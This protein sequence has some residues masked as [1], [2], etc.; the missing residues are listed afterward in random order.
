MVLPLIAV[1]VILAAVV[2]GLVVFLGRGNT[3][4]GQHR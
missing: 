1:A 4:R 3:R 2:V